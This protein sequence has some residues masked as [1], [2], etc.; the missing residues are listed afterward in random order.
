MLIVVGGFEAYNGAAV[1]CRAMPKLNVIV[2]PATIS[3]NVPGTSVSIGMDKA[4]N[5]LVDACD[6]IKQA[7]VGYEKRVHIVESIGRSCGFQ[8]LFGAICSGAE[9]CYIPEKQPTLEDVAQCARRMKE[10]LSGANNSIGLIIQCESASPHLTPAVVAALH[11]SVGVS[12]RVSALAGIQQGGH[13]TPL[14]RIFAGRL[15][16][17]A[18]QLLRE[19]GAVLQVGLGLLEDAPCWAPID[20]V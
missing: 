5:N 1:V 3:L 12:A 14:D 11:E 20:Q 7:T 4:S 18:V 15:A 13:P 2:L 6:N 16:L 19:R 17:L 10:R 9:Q 8:T